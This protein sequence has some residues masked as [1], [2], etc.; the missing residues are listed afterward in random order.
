ML[1][2][3]LVKYS[4]N[5]NVI[6]SDYLF[7]KTVQWR[8]TPLNRMI[9]LARLN[10]RTSDMKWLPTCCNG[11]CTPPSSVLTKE[12][13]LN[14]MRINNQRDPDCAQSTIEKA[15]ILH[16]KVNV[17]RDQKTGRNYSTFKDNK[18]DMQCSILDWCGAGEITKNLLET[19]GVIWTWM[20]C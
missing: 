9:N 14:S 15:W 7:I 18:K 12:F 5:R 2:K 19:I 4:C 16:K 17:K 3:L 11:K 20:V 6:P 13:N 1:G 8:K 10:S